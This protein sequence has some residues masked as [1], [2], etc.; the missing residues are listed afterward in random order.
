M[1]YCTYEDLSFTMHVFAHGLLQLLQETGTIE[2]ACAEL[3]HPSKILLLEWKW[4]K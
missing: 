1:A 4:I 2:C 3:F